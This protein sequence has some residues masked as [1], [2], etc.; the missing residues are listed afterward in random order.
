MGNLMRNTSAMTLIHQRISLLWG[1]WQEE[2]KRPF[3]SFLF[4]VLSPS[5]EQTKVS[6]RCKLKFWPMKQENW[7][8]GRGMRGV[9]FAEAAECQ[10]QRGTPSL[11]TWPWQ[12]THAH[13]SRTPIKPNSTGVFTRSS[14]QGS[15]GWNEYSRSWQGG[16]QGVGVLSSDLHD[17]DPAHY[18]SKNRI[19]QGA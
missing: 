4:S 7:K 9:G 3:P 17:I 19:T 8:P 18:L 15:G 6:S 10:L 14:Q 12:D 13:F 2:N 11:E 16:W 5:S 1:P